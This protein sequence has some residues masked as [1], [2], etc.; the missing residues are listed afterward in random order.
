MFGYTEKQVQFI[1]LAKE[2][3]IRFQGE[4]ISELK[5]ELIRERQRAD[6][7]VDELL[8]TKGI[9]TVMPEK[10]RLQPIETPEQRA[11]REAEISAMRSAL[12]SVGDLGGPEPDHGVQER[13]PT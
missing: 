8:K 13:I 1:L 11:K 5:A 12:E 7:A 6:L 10:I 3:V 9:P 4:R 2:Q